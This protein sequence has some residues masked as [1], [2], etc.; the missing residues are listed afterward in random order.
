VESFTT[1]GTVYQTDPGAESCTC[2]DWT[3]N[4]SG[5]DRGDPR[6]YCKHLLT[7]L[8]DETQS[9]PDNDPAKRQERA[10]RRIRDLRHGFPACR[11][12]EAMEILGWEYDVYFPLDRQNPWVEVYSDDGAR[13]YNV[14]ENRWDSASRPVEADALVQAITAISDEERG[15]TRARAR[16]RRL[17]VSVRMGIVTLLTF[18]VLLSG[19]LVLAV[20][21]FGGSQAVRVL[22]HAQLAGRAEATI[23]KTL[24]YL[25][26]AAKAAALLANLVEPERIKGAW[27]DGGTGQALLAALQANPQLRWTAFGTPKGDMLLAQ[28]MADG[29]ASLQTVLREGM[30]TQVLWS[31]S[32]PRWA[33][34]FRSGTKRSD[35]APDPR[36]TFWYQKAAAREVLSWSD[37]TISEVDDAPGIVCALPVLRGGA[38]QGVVGVGIDLADLALF[39][40]KLRVGR[41]GQAYILNAAR[42]IVSMPLA[43]RAQIHQ[44]VRRQAAA[45]G[46]GLSLRPADVA[47]YAPMAEAAHLFYGAARSG[48]GEDF[49]TFAK[50]G[51]N[52]VGLFKP[53]PGGREGLPWTIGL[54][55]PEDDFMGPIKDYAGIVLHVAVALI[56]LTIILGV[57]LARVFARPLDM[58]AQEMTRI[59]DFHLES[60]LKVDSPIIEVDNMGQSL[61]NMKSGLK[62]FRKFV[63]A[64]LVRDLIALGQ[65]ATLGGEYRT[66]TIMFTDIAS[67]TSISENAKPMDLVIRLGE[68]MSLMTTAIRAQ[69]GTVDK[70]IG[71]AI[72]A[73]WGAPLTLE[74]HAFRACRAALACREILRIMGPRWNATSVPAFPT[75]FGLNT[76]EAIVGNMGSDDRLNYTALGDP[77]NLAA[78]LESLNKQYGTEILI[79]EHTYEL[80]K[81]RM[82]ARRVDIVAVK[83]KTRPVAIYELVDETDRVGE[84]D[85]EWMEAY[86]RAFELYLARRWNEASSAFGRVIV[87]RGED[88]ASEVFIRRCAVYTAAPPDP[89]W[90]GV[91]VATTK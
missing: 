53:F 49:M 82:A 26:P 88:K 1:P 65:E 58:L 41:T 27:R 68:Y 40:G 3:A 87:L 75:R 44:L 30:D 45:G 57:R 77:I 25:D 16:L 15:R 66:I 54:A 56:L 42:D 9:L 13:R 8:F 37:V 10:F 43:S 85:R 35:E 63:P 29:S 2:D 28:R 47:P 70:F 14:I 46:T 32:D 34:T 23:D 18:L 19:S 48:D 38:L 17:R 6:R 11:F 31:H 81:T 36:D 84:K 50:D 89:D 20:S 51:T 86:A 61:A 59:R 5:F 74:R 79:S 4:R 24:D 52:Y 73:F 21:Y 67:F 55:A 69:Q 90:V 80:V 76:G 39:L 12:Y 71:D 33:D 7:L 22:M 72:M 83:G 91:F 64:Q 62:S 60:G 78:R